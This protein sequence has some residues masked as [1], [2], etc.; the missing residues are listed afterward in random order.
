[1]KVPGASLASQVPRELFRRRLGR[2]LAGIAPVW[3]GI[4]LCWWLAGA[5]AAAWAV[6]LAGVIVGTLQ[7][8]LNVM[9]HDGLQFLLCDSRRVNDLLCRWLLHGPHGAPLTQMRRNHLNHHTQYGAATDLD[10]QYY[11]ISRFRGAAPFLRWLLGSVLGGMTLPIV[12][13][14]L[15]L[16]KGVA[17]PAPVARVQPRDRVADLLSVLLSQAWIAVATAWLTGWW[18]AYLP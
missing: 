11:D 6:L 15:G 13:K 16:R 18:W 7:Y 9:G 8:H 14:L 4:L 17:A 10:R 5:L 12:A 3:A 2:S 1:M